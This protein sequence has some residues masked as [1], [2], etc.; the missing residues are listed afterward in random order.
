MVLR[1][2]DFDS[3]SHGDDNNKDGDSYSDDND[4][5]GPPRRHHTYNTRHRKRD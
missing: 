4:A 2:N 5:I 3:D 1:D